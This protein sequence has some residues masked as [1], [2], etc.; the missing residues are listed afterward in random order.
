MADNADNQNNN[1]G[2]DGNEN[3]YEFDNPFV[4]ESG[5]TKKEPDNNKPENDDDDDILPEDKEAFNKVA[6]KAVN[7]IKD[8]VN[9]VEGAVSKVVR[10]S[11]LNDFLSSSEGESFKPFADKIKEA[12]LNPRANNL[13]VRAVAY[14]VAGKNLLKMGAQKGV[15]AYKNEQN[16]NS[17][18][19]GGSARNSGGDNNLPDFKSMS[20]D[21]FSTFTE[22]VKAGQFKKK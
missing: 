18:G 21:E 6:N 11:E 1:E 13:T 10:T 2:G 20:R 7:P 3:Q 19:S 16:S 8:K 4:D 9:Q 17:G 5:N 22:Q 14:M 12:A 15:E